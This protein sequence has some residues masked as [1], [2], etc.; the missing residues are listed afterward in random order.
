MATHALS[1]E[2]VRQVVQFVADHTL[3]GAGFRVALENPRLTL[4]DA[5]LSRGWLRETYGSDE[6]RWFAVTD[7]GRA[8]LRVG[9]GEG[10]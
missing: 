6:F 4:Y 2:L 8:A 1:V 10:T 7:E 9:G 5:A 3:G